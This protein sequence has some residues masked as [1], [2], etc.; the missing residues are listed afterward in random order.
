MFETEKIMKQIEELRANLYKIVDGR[1]FTDQEVVA[2]SQ[3]LDVVLNEYYR[4]L[5]LK[6]DG[7]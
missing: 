2:A 1:T 4:L 7:S 5:K 6:V 3:K